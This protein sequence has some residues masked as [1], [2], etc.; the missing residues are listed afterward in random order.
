MDE[1]EEEGK[2][3][4]GLLDVSADNRDGSSRDADDEAG[5]GNDDMEEEQ[6][7]S[8]LAASSAKVKT[9]SRPKKSNAELQSSI[10]KKKTKLQA[11]KDSVASDDDGHDEKP[12]VKKA[13]VV[14]RNKETKTKNWIELL[15]YLTW[16]K[17]ILNWLNDT[18]KT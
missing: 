18:A 12:L 2:V 4:E 15:I 6:K 13:P 17:L 14:R 8:V 10:G 7:V 11:S 3:P 9:N 5:L 1:Q 16:S